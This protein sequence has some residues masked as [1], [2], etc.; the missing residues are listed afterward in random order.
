MSHALPLPGSA[1]TMVG[2]AA[3]LARDWNRLRCLAGS[4]HVPQSVTGCELF[5]FHP[6]G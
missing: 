1:A 3:D 5:L 2:K 4:G 6:E